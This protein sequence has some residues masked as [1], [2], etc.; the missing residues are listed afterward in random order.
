[1]ELIINDKPCTSS[2][3]QTLGKVARLNH[4]HV[5][6]ICGGHGVCQ[7][8]YVTVQEGADCLAPLTDIEKAFLSPRQIAAGGRMACQATIDK[9]GVVKVLSRP[10]ELRR[11]LITNPFGLIGY[12]AEMG[13]DAAQQIVPGIQ[14]LAGRIS[15]GEMGGREAIGD[16]MESVS[17]AV[18]LVLETLPQMI[19]FSGQLTGLLSDL[20]SKLP[21]PLPFAAPTAPAAPLERVTITVAAP[22]Y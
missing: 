20:P 14:N 19:P 7:A 4:S 16:L 11:M 6:Y 2:V 22:R 18:G 5:G 9:E 1:M 13:R 10:E 3:G 12:V 8:C 15:R 17:G 21:F